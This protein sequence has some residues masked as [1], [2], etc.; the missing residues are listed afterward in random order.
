MSFSNASRSRQGPP[1]HQSPGSPVLAEPVAPRGQARSDDGFWRDGLNV[2]LMTQ[3]ILADRMEVP[4]V[5]NGFHAK[6]RW[7]RG[8]TALARPGSFHSTIGEN[9]YICFRC[10]LYI[11]VCA[12]FEF[13]ISQ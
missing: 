4:M 13:Y 9:T 12:L 11:L 2:E 5:S 3:Q 7:F 8:E 10:I 6:P 1:W